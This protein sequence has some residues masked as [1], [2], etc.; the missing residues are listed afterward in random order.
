MQKF[1]LAVYSLASCFLY[2]FHTTFH[3]GPSL[4]HYIYI[5]L[6]RLF[7]LFLAFL[8]YLLYLLGL[9]R[10]LALSLYFCVLIR[11]IHD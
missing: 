10:T 5:G 1:S 3:V 7:A 4:H 9:T 8:L 11:R 6:L 2:N